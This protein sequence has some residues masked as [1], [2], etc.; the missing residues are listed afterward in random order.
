[1]TVGASRITSFHSVT[2][3]PTA[4]SFNVVRETA[5][6]I[7]ELI[8]QEKMAELRQ[9]VAEVEAALPPG[10]AMSSDW[11]KPLL[12]GYS[13]SQLVKEHDYS[14]DALS[15]LNRDG[16]GSGYRVHNSYQCSNVSSPGANLL[17]EHGGIKVVKA[18]YVPVY[19][20]EHK[21]FIWRE[22]TVYP[23]IQLHQSLYGQSS[24]VITRMPLSDAIT[25]SYP[26]RAWA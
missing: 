16:W 13:V 14:A 22:K 4:E 19:S 25:H 23:D 9:Q 18:L 8:H 2:F 5:L 1:M 11:L 3:F 7:S 15:I 24:S 12:Q 20:S 21:D 10:M 17:E 6:Q 26:S